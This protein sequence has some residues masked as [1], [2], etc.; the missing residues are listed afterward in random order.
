MSTISAGT[1]VINSITYTGDTTG[2]L[3]FQTNN[4][5]TAVTIDANQNFI[6]ASSNGITFSDGS[7]QSKSASIEAIPNLLMLGGM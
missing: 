7:K 4:T 2:N 3:V 1:Q 5:T 6:F